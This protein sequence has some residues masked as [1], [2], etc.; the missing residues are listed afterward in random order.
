MKLRDSVLL[1]SLVLGGCMVGPDYQKPAMPLPQSF[2][3][4]AQWQRAASNPQGAMDSQWWLAYQDPVLNDLVARSAKANQSIIAAEAAYRLSQAQV[5]SSRAGLWPTVGVGL[6][7]SRGS[8]GSSSSTT[9]SATTGGV[10][11]SVSATLTASW[12]PD[13]WGQV[14]RGIESSQATA[15]Q[16]DALLAGVRLSI[17]SSVASNY[18]ALR[19]MDID[20]RLLQQQQT[21]NQQLLE[22]IQAQFT[23]GVA[24][25]DQLLVAQDQL[26]TSIADLQTSLR[27]REQYE[28]A[29]A[30]LVGMAPSEF[31]VAPRN[32]FTFIVPRP[33][34]TLPSTLL[35]RRPDVVAAER[36]AAAANAKIGVAE[37]A[38]FPSLD[39]TAEV[40]YRGSALGGLFS[41]PNRIWTLGPALAETLFD[42]G[43][44]EA[45]V[46]QAEASYDQIAATYRGTVLSALQNVEDNLSAINHLQTQAD[47]FQQIYQRNQQLFG[48]QEAQ[49][50][51]GTVSQEA[52]LTQQLVLLQAEQNLRD[53][54]GQLSQGS[55][56]LIQSLGGGWQVIQH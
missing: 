26:T 56:A 23:Q 42:G 38:F 16:S 33:P 30:V 28:H 12:E 55:V 10:Q 17:S 1:I 49:L 8:S 48:S 40:G 35:Q 5:A 29:L 9:S 50:R 6:S 39:L 27:D 36:S 21:I 32:D 13:L 51:A 19:Q 45:A 43:A 22:M 54:Q 53:T 31:S 18:L 4:G 20:V 25:N 37:A 46:K 52:V 24:T 41:L 15:Q 14:R 44:R 2:K 7:G 47:A 3:E 34:L 11:N